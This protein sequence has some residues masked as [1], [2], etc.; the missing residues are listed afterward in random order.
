MRLTPPLYADGFHA[1]K[2]QPLLVQAVHALGHHR[3]GD[4]QLVRHLAPAMSPGEQGDHLPGAVRLPGQKR[5]PVDAE[6]SLSDPEPGQ[7]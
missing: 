1:L 4:A 5:R 7:S 6:A 2:R 3:G